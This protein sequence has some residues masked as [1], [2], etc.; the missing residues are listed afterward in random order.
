M[1]ERKRVGI[2]PTFY[3]VKNNNKKFSDTYYK[4]DINIQFILIKKGIVM[5][6]HNPNPNNLTYSPSDM[7]YV[8]K[9][10]REG[11]IEYTCYS[12]VQQGYRDSRGSYISPSLHRSVKER[13]LG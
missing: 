5:S 7:V 4:S 8:E 13:T 10:Y 12:L 2:F 1:I 9:L 11:K 3:A 6:N